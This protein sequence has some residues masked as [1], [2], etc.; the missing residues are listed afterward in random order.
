MLQKLTILDKPRLG[1][2][3]DCNC[4]CRKR[5]SYLWLER[6]PAQMQNAMADSH[7]L[8]L[9]DRILTNFWMFVLLVRCLQSFQP[10]AINKIDINIK[11]P[12]AINGLLRLIY[13]MRHNLFSSCLRMSPK[14]YSLK[15]YKRHEFRFG[16]TKSRHNNWAKVLHH[17]SITLKQKTENTI[18]SS[19][20]DQEWYTCTNWMIV[21]EPNRKTSD[22]GNIIRQLN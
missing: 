15:D 1:M 2:W 3:L 5:W 20:S 22:E 7:P 21:A 19:L 13:I 4:W 12:F 8:S 14:K 6:R 9:I 10:N 16:L 17:P 18:S 11:T